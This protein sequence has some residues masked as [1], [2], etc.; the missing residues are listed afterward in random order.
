MTLRIEVHS[1]TA[2][3]MADL[4][5]FS[6]EQREQLA[7]LLDGAN[8]SLWREVLYGI[9]TGD[10]EIVAVAMSQIGN[11]GGEP[12]WSWYRVE[13]CACFISWCANQCGYLEAGVIPKFAGVGTGE[14]WFKA[15]GLWQ[16]RHYEP[17]PGDI[18]FFDWDRDG[19]VDHVGLV[20]KAEDGWVYTIEGNSNDACR[21]RRYALG[22]G[23]IYGYG[24]PEYTP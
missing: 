5:N 17:S 18:I 2:W 15:R 21:E 7:A 3:E 6:P 16:D 11:V 13:W 24:T 10:G 8:R 9:G 4:L 12:Y 1:K 19:N 14:D 22:H 23:Q 20:E